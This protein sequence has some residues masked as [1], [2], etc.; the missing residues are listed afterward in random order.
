[1]YVGLRALHRPRQRD[2]PSA[3][4]RPYFPLVLRSGWSAP[5]SYILSTQSGP[6]RRPRLSPT[7]LDPNLDPIRRRRSLLSPAACGRPPTPPELQPARSARIRMAYSRYGLSCLDAAGGEDGRDER[8]G[9]LRRACTALNLDARAD[10]PSPST[11]L[12]AWRCPWD[13][14]WP[15]AISSSR[16]RQ[17]LQRAQIRTSTLRPSHWEGI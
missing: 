14:S 5:A 15:R 10:S 11:T 12:R 16:Y 9:R 6:P 1:M 4:E 7:D 8:A 3:P 13:I 2:V 17:A